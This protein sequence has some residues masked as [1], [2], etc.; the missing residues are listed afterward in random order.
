MKQFVRRS[1]E[2]LAIGSGKRRAWLVLSVALLALLAWGVPVS[3]AE[4]D[5]RTKPEPGVL[6]VGVGEE[7]PAA[8]AGLARGDILLAIDGDMV[9]TAAEL[10]HVILM[11]D[12]G[13]TLELTVKRGEEELT[14]TVTLGDRDGYPLLGVAAHD[15]R[16]G[17]MSPQRGRFRGMREHGPTFGKQ[18]GMAFRFD[19]GRG[20]AVMEVLDDGP[21]AA[22]DLRAGDLITAVDETE[23]ARIE[24]LVKAAAAYSPGDEVELTVDRDG[25]TITLTV[26]LGAHSDDQEK[27]YIGARIL[28][29][30]RFRLDMDENGR[31][32][33][34]RRWNRFG[35]RFP[36]GRESDG[37]LFFKMMTDGA[38]VM[39]VQDEGPAANAEL[40]KGDVITAVDET[41]IASLE[42]LVEALANYGPGNEVELTVHRDGET[43]QSTVTLGAHPDDESKAYLGVMIMPATPFR[44]RLKDHG[45]QAQEEPQR[46]HESESS[47]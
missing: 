13:D 26:T 19:G 18:R 9:N 27:A 31:D 32:D 14:L 34:M 21:A 7:M 30:E 4:L 38:L 44:M 36:N 29:S 16:D 43:I 1:S 46:G 3:A 12:P 42:E 2:T 6:I 25:E 17:R 24:D 11:R 39:D 41:E 15:P 47:S 23:I 45:E 37:R 8:E 35:F 20:A 5:E 10:K 40:E 22:A 28:P 33:G